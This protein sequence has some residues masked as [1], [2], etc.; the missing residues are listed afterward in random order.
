[1]KIDIIAAGIQLPPTAEAAITR[2]A[3]FELSRF[4]DN[5]RRI[6]IRISKETTPPLGLDIACRVIIDWPLLGPIEAETRH[7]DPVLAAYNAVSRVGRSLACRLKIAN[8]R[9]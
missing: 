9:L 6:K 8:Q 2:H 4:S 3:Y 7:S 1:M 5:L